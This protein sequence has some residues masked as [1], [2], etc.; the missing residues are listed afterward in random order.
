MAPVLFCES[1]PI[2]R[3]PGLTR[4]RKCDGS[5][6][7]GWHLMSNQRGL[8]AYSTWR[9]QFGAS[10]FCLTG[11]DAGALSLTYCMD[12]EMMRFN[13]DHGAWRMKNT[14]QCWATPEVSDG[15]VPALAG[16]EREKAE[17]MWVLKAADA[18]QMHPFE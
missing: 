16:C 6:A 8:Q 5:Q 18:S 11:S 9:F 3:N 17:Q 12:S 13:S 7:Q 14:E 1:L 4:R 2:A 10:R 15:A